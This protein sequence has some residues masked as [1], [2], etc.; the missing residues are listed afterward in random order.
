[1]NSPNDFRTFVFFFF[2]SF[3][4]L[5]FY[6]IQKLELLFLRAL[7]HRTLHHT[8]KILPLLPLTNTTRTPRPIT[9]NHMPP[10]A[11]T[12]SMMPR[13][14]TTLGHI[15]RRVFCLRFCIGN[16]GIVGEG[17]GGEGEEKSQN[18]QAFHKSLLSLLAREQFLKLSLFRDLQ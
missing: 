7:Y 5:F 15:T 13:T 12:H 18:Q 16:D 1:M 9:T 3:F 11:P 2:S 14:T 17:R 8:D 6:K 10:L 4:L